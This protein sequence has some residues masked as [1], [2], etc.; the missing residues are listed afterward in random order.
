MT[1]NDT[2]VKILFA[3]QIA[4]LPM[5]MAAYL[6]LPAWSIG[7]FIAGVLV[8]KIWFELFK[9]KDDRNHNIISAI[10]SA[11]TISS[12]VIFFTVE[13]YVNVVVCV[14]VVI[15]AVLTNIL[16]V[17]LF[18]S[19]MPELIDAVDSCFMLFE[20]LMIAALTFIVFYQLVT[21]I[22]LFAL[23]LTSA[24]SVAYKIYHIMR[25]NGGWDKIRSLFRRK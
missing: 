6:L 23:L 9:N 16:K 22:A 17:V 2:F 15:L 18:G 5:S 20:C 14:F 11:A 21:N 7:L 12:L 25:F 13:N 3:I 10:A 24:V 4:L 1:R 19:S 8:A